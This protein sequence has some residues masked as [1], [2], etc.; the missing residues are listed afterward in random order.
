MDSVLRR[1]IGIARMKST[2]ALVFGFCLI[3]F[4]FGNIP[5]VV[6]S[7]ENKKPTREKNLL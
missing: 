6:S 4:L 1:K 2:V 3:V 7:A 5:Q